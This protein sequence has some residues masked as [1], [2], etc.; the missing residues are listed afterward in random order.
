MLNTV[1]SEQRGCP[2]LIHHQVVEI[3][4]ERGDC[5]AVKAKVQHSQ[6]L[7]EIRGKAI[8]NAAGAWS[9]QVAALAGNRL[10][11][12]LSKGSLIISSHRLSN[13]VLNRLRPNSDGDIIVPNET[14]CLC[15]TT[16]IP[17]QLADLARVEPEEVDLL[18]REAGAMVPDFAETRL[19]R[20][21]AGVR[22]LLQAESGSENDRAISRGFRIFDHGNR[23]FSIVGGKLSTY[24]LMAE[25][26]SD[27]IQEFFGLKLPCTTAE[28]PLEG[29][30]DLAGYPL[31]K[32]LGKIS[33]IVCE[34]ELVGR[35]AVENVVEQTNTK[36][37]EDIQHRTR[38][39]MGPCQGGF[40]TYRALGI[41]QEQG[42]V[43]PAE[44]L[45]VLK[46]FLRRWFKGIKPVLWGDQ[47][48]EEQFVEGIYLGI[49]DL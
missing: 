13:M 5:V 39:G 3:T 24:R 10:P 44:S 20:A 21:Y 16:S 31:S 8:I 22:A 19:I 12:K 32:R 15:G 9:G 6:E 1:S 37:I 45:R 34:C 11:L 23:M 35:Q 17:I 4:K 26:M 41:M 28:R 25:K 43:D 38:L 49:L 27:T 29:Q 42:S 48:R 36:Y 46:A 7:V 18:L 47:L 33:D 30:Q 14:V 40:C 2:V